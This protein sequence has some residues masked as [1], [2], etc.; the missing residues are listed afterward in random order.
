M[1]SVKHKEQSIV[2]LGSY[3]FIGGRWV[4][5][6]VALVSTGYIWHKKLNTFRADC[7]IPRLLQLHKVRLNL[8]KTEFGNDSDTCIDTRDIIIYHIY[9]R[10]KLSWIFVPLIYSTD[11]SHSLNLSVAQNPLA[12]RFWA[13]LCLQISC[14]LIRS[15][16]DINQASSR[17][18]A[19]YKVRHVLFQVSSLW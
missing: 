8:W 3:N 4:T 6:R 17:H 15:S 16:S 2:L 10:L 18:K 5:T 19:G 12:H 9:I 14:H 13:S 7:T 1:S 11:E